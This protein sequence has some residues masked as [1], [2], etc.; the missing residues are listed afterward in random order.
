MTIKTSDWSDIGQQIAGAY[1]RI[2][3]EVRATAL[4][5][6]LGAGV[7]AGA[8][9]LTHALTPRDPDE[10]S[11]LGRRMGLGAL[12]GG[13]LAMAAPI[14]K[15][16]LSGARTFINEQSK[17]PFESALGALGGA[18]GG[19]WGATL[20]GG[21]GAWMGLKALRNQLPMESS[22]FRTWNSM[23]NAK[24]SPLIVRN[25]LDRF[26]NMPG[27]VG[28]IHGP[29]DIKSTLERAATLGGKDNV[30][31]AI[32]QML[33]HLHGSTYQTAGDFFQPGRSIPIPQAVRSVGNRL[34]DMLGRTARV[35]AMTALPK[36]RQPLIATLKNMKDPR[37]KLLGAILAGTAA[38]GA[39]H[40]SFKGSM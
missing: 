3:E 13:G 11:H 24:M 40:G 9:G 27:I 31:T 28:G 7:G 36:L 23:S 15:D 5:G 29:A 2:P 21:T 1:N 35:P 34:A 17:G 16:L 32:R 30:R 20:G 12:A 18:A 19:H 37:L 14:G 39:I 33:S 22:L 26:R 38:G 8:L 6:L 4:R 25:L 10:E